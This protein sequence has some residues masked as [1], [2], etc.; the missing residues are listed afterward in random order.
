MKNK[1][2]VSQMVRV[3][4]ELSD[5]DASTLSENFVALGDVGVVMG[6]RESDNGFNV[7][8]HMNGNGARLYF[9]EE[10][11]EEVEVDECVATGGMCHFVSLSV[12]SA[13]MTG[14][15]DGE[16]CDVIQ[17]KYCGRELGDE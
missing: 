13:Y 5:E 7:D 16:P 15:E 1:F 14:E 3:I 2:K 9:K 17:C 10:E 11:L 4:S 12:P 8:V 6:F